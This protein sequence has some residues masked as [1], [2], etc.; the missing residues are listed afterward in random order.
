MVGEDNEFV[1]ERFKGLQVIANIAFPRL[2]E[3]KEKT[4]KHHMYDIEAMWL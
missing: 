2:S 4:P 1:P 3:Q